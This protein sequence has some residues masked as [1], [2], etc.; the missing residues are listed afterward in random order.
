MLKK[1]NFTREKIHI[2]VEIGFRINGYYYLQARYNELII[3]KT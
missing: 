3:E 1:L 2:D